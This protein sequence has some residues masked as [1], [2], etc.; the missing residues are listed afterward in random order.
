M[1][2]RRIGPEIIELSRVAGEV[3]LAF[4]DEH[5]LR[6]VMLSVPGMEGVL[7]EMLVEH[8]YPF[9]SP[10]VHVG[11]RDYKSMLRTQVPRWAPIASALSRDGGCPCCRSLTCDGNWSPSCTLVDLVKEIRDVVETRRRVVW[12]YYCRV[13]SSERL[14]HDVPLE[15]YL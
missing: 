3:R 1:I 9:R 7:V 2:V 8:N 5:T 13:I 6:L 15:S 10:V 12:I 11:S 4:E 14:T